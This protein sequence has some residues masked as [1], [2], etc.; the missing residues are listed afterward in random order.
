MR[1]TTTG[2][3]LLSWAPV[4]DAE[5]YE[6]WRRTGKETDVKIGNVGT[7]RNNDRLKVGDKQFDDI[8]FT[9]IVSKTNDILPDTEYTYTVVAYATSSVKDDGKWSGKVKTSAT[10]PAVGSKPSAP[11]DVAYAY[12]PIKRTLAITITPADSGIL[13]AGYWFTVVRNG[14]WNQGDD[15]EGWIAHDPANN[16]P[17]TWTVYLD[18]D[19][20]GRYGNYYQIGVSAFISGRVYH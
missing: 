20:N 17:F 13:P 5:G 15:E 3:V 8:Q 11:K 6:V 19:F 1:S 7:P 14:N 4:L 18:S 10:F 2:G 16:V 9:D 12:D